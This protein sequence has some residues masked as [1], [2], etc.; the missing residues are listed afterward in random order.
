[1]KYSFENHCRCVRNSE[2]IAIISIIKESIVCCKNR[3]PLSPLIRYSDYYNFC[4]FLARISKI[5][6]RHRRQRYW[7]VP[8]KNEDSSHFSTSKT[9]SAAV[10]VQTNLHLLRFH[11]LVDYKYINHVCP[12]GFRWSRNVLGEHRRQEL[13]GTWFA[14]S[15]R[16]Q[17]GCW[18][19]RN[20]STV[21]LRGIVGSKG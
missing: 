4:E 10:H 12:K 5:I 16:F 7:N 17:M 21:L 11:S 19:G 3:T 15:A 13:A 18:K 8:Q 9:F 14:G 2:S 6:H 20:W 1:M